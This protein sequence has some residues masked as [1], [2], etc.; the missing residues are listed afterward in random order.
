[1]II[2]T[3]RIEEA[4]A[5]TSHAGYHQFHEASTGEDMWAAHVC[6]GV[7]HDPSSSLCHVDK[8]L[9]RRSYG[10]FEV[11][12]HDGNPSEYVTEYDAE[13]GEHATMKPGWYW[14]AGFPGCLPDG[15]AMGP[16]ASSQ[17]AHEDADEWAPEY[18]A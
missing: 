4:Q 11:F 12:W 6:D 16:F 13:L 2:G 17:Q 1:M 7:N 3:V 14:W 9:V 8:C 5:Y 15:D 10:S 18:D